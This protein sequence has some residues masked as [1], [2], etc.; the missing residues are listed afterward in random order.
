MKTVA[1]PIA[2]LGALVVA[3]GGAWEPYSSESGNEPD[4]EL[5]EQPRVAQSA[6]TEQEVIEQYCVRCHSDRRMQGNLSLEDFDATAPHERAQVA[7]KMIVKLRTGMMPPPGA[8]RPAGDTLTSLVR[9]IEER[10]DRA[11]AASPQPG[12][13]TFQRLNRVEYSRSI[14]DL[15]GLQIDA[16][17]YLPLDTKAD[18]FDNIADVQLLSPT[19][20]DAYMNAAAEISRLAVGDPNAA[21][22]ERTYTVSGYVSQDERVDGAPFGT[23]GGVSIEHNFPADGDY[24]FT[25]VPEHTTTGSGFFG[26]I[27]RYQQVEISING[28]RK[29][30]LDIDQWM[31]VADPEGIS[32]RTP[33]IFV[34]AGPQRV[35]AA[36]IKRA[37][38]PAE[39]LLSPHDWTLADRHTGMGGY[40]LR[41]LP[42]IRDL[43]V[44]G[45]RR[46][47][48]VSDNP[49]RDRIFTCRPVEPRD[50]EPCAERILT[51]LAEQAYRRPVAERDREALLR[52]YEM[53]AEE[54]GF[55]V[56]IRTGLQALLASPHFIFRFEGPADSA[57]PGEAF[58]ISDQ[59]LASRLSFFLWGRPPDEELRSV[60]AD[61]RLSNDAEL[62]RQVRRMLEDPRSEALAT[63]FA[64]QW[65]RLPDLDKVHPDQFW[66]P[67]YDQQLANAMRRET[68]LFF[69][70]LVREDRS[71]LDLYNADYTFVNERLARHYGIDGVVGD[72]FKRVR[73]PGERRRGILGHGSVL[74]LTSHAGRTS[75]VLRGKWVMEVLMGSPPPPPPPGVPP[76]DETSDQVTDGRVLTTKER[77][78]MHRANP[79]CN[80][81]H[82]FIDPI[83]LALD[84]FDVTGKW[85]IKENGVELDT[86]GELY[87][88]TPV[89][90][91]GAL[92]EALL[93]RPIPLLR[94]FT[95]NLMAYALG[96]LVEYRDQPTVRHIVSE[97]EKKD[98]RMSA[99]ILG[100]VKSDAFRMQ[101]AGTATDDA[102]N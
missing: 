42:H 92:T 46:V 73:Y 20:L 34:P 11:A 76:L 33:P 9:S 65:L 1:A 64:A 30:L 82:R 23:R 37:E 15:L 80:A 48:G 47:T 63:R 35:T 83:G 99:F 17:D 39:D 95:E 78:E 91:P 59:A 55:E 79:T 7:E 5:A 50:E 18:N 25:I 2:A 36:F 88:G 87:D 14:E 32:M 10:V 75:P 61:G 8:N 6:A 53:G 51:D 101:G 52:F 94:T 31:D 13:R 29:A 22:S 81:C 3:V 4:D 44:A 21:Y 60:A 40:G 97:A 19:L 66:Y 85:R 69:H 84:N 16:G 62:E 45:P 90:S 54:G 43:I 28:E 93:S 102:A 71:V 41:L 24:I 26:Q 89:D 77:M 96:R 67:D 100:V 49:V 98:Y 57:T 58:E 72:Q 70:S 68:E 38:G 56:G 12:Q 27:A 86:R 74:T